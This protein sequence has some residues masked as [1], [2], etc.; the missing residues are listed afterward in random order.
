V[1]TN[2]G[3]RGLIAA[4]QRFDLLSAVRVPLSLFCYLAPLLVLP[5][6]HELGP[7]IFVLV[8][9]RFAGWIMLMVLCLKVAPILRGVV[10]AG[11][12]LSEMF[13]FG[14]WMTITNIVSPIMVNLDRLLIGGLISM[15]AVSYYATPYEAVTRLWIIPSAVTG[16]LFPAF[17]TALGQDRA[18]AAEL[19]QR[20]V[21]YLFV[22]L[23]PI[24]IAAL[25]LGPVVLRIW[26]GAEFA[27]HSIIVLRLLAAGVFANSLAQVPFWHIQAAGRP[28]LAAK[29]HLLELPCYLLLFWALTSKYGVE[30]AGLAALLRSSIDALIVFWL[31]GGLLLEI[32]E[33]LRKLAWVCAAAIPFLVG[34]SMMNA[35]GPAIIFAAGV[36]VAFLCGAWT[37]FLSEGERQLARRPLSLFGNSSRLEPVAGH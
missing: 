8:A 18:R 9:S 3:L 6:S 15:A 24:V 37:F 35:L 25:A 10:V 21:K 5:F 34:A 26:L 2:G 11:A 19:F 23:F 28:D 31:S 12:P 20:A 1:I 32:R 17:S 14:G 13:R 16:V 27:Q 33:W 7:F 4:Y 30:G 22:S 36:D 29:A